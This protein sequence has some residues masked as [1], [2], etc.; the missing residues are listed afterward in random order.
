MARIAYED[1]AFRGESLA[2]IERANQI[3][4]SYA[5]QGYSL[6]LR[7]LYYQFVQRNWLRN[8]EQSYKRLGSIVNDGRMAGMIDWDHIVDRTR[9]SNRQPVWDSP[10]DIIE[11]VANQYRLDR[12]EG[13]PIRPEVW[14]EKEA[15]VD[16]IAVP[17]RRWSLRWFAC[18]GYAS[19]S[20]QHEAAMRFVNQIN[21]GQTPVILH[22][23]DHDPSGIDMTR[24]ITDRISRFV[25]YHTGEDVEVRRLAL[26]MDQIEAYNPPPNPAK[27]TDARFGGYAARFGDE[28]W[29]LDA[30]DPP[31]IDALISDEVEGLIHSREVWDARTETEATER[32]MLG[33]LSKRWDAV[34][35]SLL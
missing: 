25:Y 34:A 32:R 16:V 15:L 3:A 19:A 10:S 29:E 22:L 20:S 17:A 4:E 14:V 27:A 13:Q 24:D 7:Q 21:S 31:T 28:S 30:L 9:E 11:A 12:W 26:N 35:E 2:I 18:R 6:T 33:N 1:K 23:G 5:A 8:T